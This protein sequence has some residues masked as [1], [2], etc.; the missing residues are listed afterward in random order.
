VEG[1]N[2]GA[3]QPGGG[4]IVVFGAERRPRRPWLGR[5]LLAGL[6]IAALV[7][8]VDHPSGQ[9]AEHT[10]TKPPTVSVT[11]FDLSIL[12]ISADWE[13]FGLSTDS[14]V[15]IQFAR[16]QITRTFLSPA[17]R[18][19]PVSLIV[20]PHQV[21]VTPL[22]G[23]QGYVVPTG[24]A[25]RS[26]SSS[27]A[28]GGRLLPG[29]ATAEEWHIGVGQQVTRSSGRQY[30][31]TPS[32]PRPAGV[33]LV[34]VGPTNWLGL[35]CEQGHCRNVVVN[36]TTGARRTLPGA[37]L[38]VVTW[39][40]EPGIVSPDGS[41]AAVIVTSGVQRSVLDLVNVNTGR[42][43]TMPVPIDESSDS[44]AL[45]WSPDSRWLFALAASGKLVAIRVSDG[46]VHSIGVRL[47]VLSQ[48]A[49]RATAG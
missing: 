19:A 9:R 16:G 34:A 2:P 47:P 3:Y 48:I 42:T 17:L 33:L 31:T 49:M 32:D 27:L 26:L 40:T 43:T 14:L 45:A 35:T 39:P 23:V 1:S 44:Q 5:L 8:V 7:F 41:L 25:G 21:V 15:S 38:N 20:G 18:A 4:E 10:A 46:T 30:S 29:P 28:R 13:L 37:A 24:Q 12:G 22:Y 11:R 6:V 36:T